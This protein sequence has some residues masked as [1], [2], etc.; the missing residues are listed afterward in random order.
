MKGMI[1]SRGRFDIFMG[2]DDVAMEMNDVSRLVRR[3]QLLALGLIT[4]EFEFT[5]N[6]DMF[7]TLR[8]AIKEG[9]FVELTDRNNKNL[10]QDDNNDDNNDDD[11]D[12][13][14]EKIDDNNDSNDI[15]QE[16]DPLIPVSFAFSFL[17]N[18]PSWEEDLEQL[19]NKNH[20]LVPVIHVPPKLTLTPLLNSLNDSGRR[21][22]YVDPDT[23]SH[24]TR[25]LHPV[26][27]VRRHIHGP[28]IYLI[29][30]CIEVMGPS[31]W[32][33]AGLAAPSVIWR[34]QVRNF[35]I[36][37]III[38]IMIIITIVIITGI[39]SKGDRR[40]FHS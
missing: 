3:S 6:R 26:P 34:L 10:D 13:N 35:I 1:L 38:I 20:S 18:N 16:A 25:I 21:V 12:N 24:E 29:P 39:G 37:I 14:N 32:F 27:F 31:R 7:E 30:E 36:I 5:S 19:L 2:I 17:K 8:T 40:R 15:S 4:P 23:D 33:F 22:R 28:V 9:K 11:N